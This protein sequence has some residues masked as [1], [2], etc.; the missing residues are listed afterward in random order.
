[1]ARS[2]FLS[3]ELVYTASFG[4]SAASGIAVSRCLASIN[5]WKTPQLGISY[6][7]FQSRGQTTLDHLVA[8]D[9]YYHHS[10]IPRIPPTTIN[11]R[12][13]PTISSTPDTSSRAP[14]TLYG[15]S[16]VQSARASAVLTHKDTTDLTFNHP[17]VSRDTHLKYLRKAPCCVLGGYLSNTRYP[18]SVALYISPNKP[19]NT[20]P[21]PS[22]QGQE[23]KETQCS[24]QG[25]L[26]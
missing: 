24:S 7:Q 5:V 6:T 19:L 21:C 14:P 2:I 20:R 12:S 9:Y 3:W 15:I 18:L 17:R 26:S 4:L 13:V 8:S 10:S 16:H 11:I 23:T 1:M 25:R 22:A